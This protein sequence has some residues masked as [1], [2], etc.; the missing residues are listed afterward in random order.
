MKKALKVFAILL[1][2]TLLLRGWIYRYSVNYTSIGTRNSIEITNQDLLDKIQIHSNDQ[3]ADIQKI[4]KIANS[5]TIETLN[6]T[7]GPTS[8]NPNELMQT[9][10]AN[11]IGYSALFNS[12]AN[13][14]ITQ[15]QLTDRIQA[16]HHIGQLDFLGIN[17]HQLFS[18]PFFKDH[19][20]NTLQDLQTGK[21]YAIDPSLSDY[22]GIKRVAFESYSE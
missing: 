13:Q 17:L 18:H 9:R 21:V 7:G 20:F 8:N 6:F 1:L 3:Q 5:I 10:Q 12:I 11:C 15:Y 14:L 16:K 22:L 2:T 4:I 19:D